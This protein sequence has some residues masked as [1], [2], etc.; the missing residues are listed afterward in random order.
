MQVQIKLDEHGKGA[1]I[2]EDQGKE[3]GRME[4]SLHH[5]EIIA[6]HTE[7]IPEEEG[8][9]YSKRLVEAVT[10]YARMNHLTIVPLCSFVQSQFKKHEDEYGDVW[11]R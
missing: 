6:Y 9:G 4:V 10:E 7:I 5:N 3:L 11:K 2:L 8:H 1:F